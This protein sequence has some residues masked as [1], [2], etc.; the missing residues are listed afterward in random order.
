MRF[1]ALEGVA[2]IP[3]DL[4]R[5]KGESTQCGYSPQRSQFK[6]RGIF[7][8]SRR[9]F[10]ETKSDRLPQRF[11]QLH[12]EGRDGF[13]VK[14]LGG[15]NASKQALQAFPILVAEGGSTQQKRAYLTIQKEG[16]EWGG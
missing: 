11:I 13:R 15:K 8:L 16:T 2:P 12:V 7:I 10:Q 3:E 4:G 1:A 5:F 6:Q 14:T 9:P